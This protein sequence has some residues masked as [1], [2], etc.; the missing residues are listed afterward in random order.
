MSDQ[1]KEGAILFFGKAGCANCHNGPNLANMEFHAQG[2][3]DL[4]ET[5]ELTYGADA[6][7]DANLGRYSFTKEEADKYKFKV[8]QLYNLADSP[9]YGHGSSFRSIR[10]VVA[11]KNA[12][13]KENPNVP[14][15]QL[16]EDFRPLGLTESEIDAITAFIE[17][18][19]RDPNLLRYQPLSIRS[20]N[21][22]P[23]NDQMSKDDL[24]CN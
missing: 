8:P 22:F 6:N 7:S 18:G 13:I 16:P 4:F 15:E 10:D 12:G 17:G 3:K 24:G 5:N 21:C 20:G 2:M 9:F 19:L 23:N 14:D 1:E 11:Y